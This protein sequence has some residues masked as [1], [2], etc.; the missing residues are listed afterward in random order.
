[1]RQRAPTVPPTPSTSFESLSPIEFW[2]YQELAKKL[3]TLKPKSHKGRQP[4]DN[5][6][7]NKQYDSGGEEG[8]HRAAF[9]HGR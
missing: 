2:D 8:I 4:V 3:G 7:I 1:M 5:S 6:Q 9:E